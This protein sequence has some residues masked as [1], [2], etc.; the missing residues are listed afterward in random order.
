[1]KRLAD[2]VIDLFVGMCVVSR[3]TRML[4]EH[5]KEHCE[6]PLVMAKVFT[7]QA[8][9]RINQ[10]LRR[11]DKYDEDDQMKALSDFIVAEGGFPWDL[12]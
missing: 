12:V 2:V 7:K 6:Q 5:S 3:V 8:R 1:M 10:N 4:A 11:I 9:R